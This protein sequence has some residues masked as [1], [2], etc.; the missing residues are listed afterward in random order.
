MHILHPYRYD[1]LTL[2]LQCQCTCTLR[3]Y[4]YADLKVK[5]E[6]ARSAVD[7]KQILDD[8]Q[9]LYVKT[10]ATEKEAQSSA[11]VAQSKVTVPYSQFVIDVASDIKLATSEAGKHKE[12]NRRTPPMLAKRSGRSAGSPTVAITASASDD[13]SAFDSSVAGHSNADEGKGKGE[14][15]ESPHNNTNLLLTS[16]TTSTVDKEAGSEAVKLKRSIRES[17]MPLVVPKN[18]SPRA[19][20]TGL[21]YC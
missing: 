8:P 19:G 9:V 13:A 20:E 18:E 16:P 6:E 21:L 11:A 17:L 1:L 2:N 5:V 3:Y 10:P 15:G 4:R 14:S 7:S 12:L